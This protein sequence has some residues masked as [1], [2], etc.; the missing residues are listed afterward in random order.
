MTRARALLRWLRIEDENAVLSLTTIG[1]VVGCYCLLAGKAISLPELSAFALVLG[2]YHGK[3]YLQHKRAQA[4]VQNAHEEALQKRSDEAE[5]LSEQVNALTA[6]VKELATPERIEAVK[7]AL[8]R[9]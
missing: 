3:R 9:P 1:F 6:K 5:A 4:E 2:A 7:R 8:G